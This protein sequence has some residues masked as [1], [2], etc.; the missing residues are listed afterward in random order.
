MMHPQF[1]SRHSVK[2]RTIFWLAKPGSGSRCWLFLELLLVLVTPA[3]T[4]LLTVNVVYI[5]SLPMKSFNRKYFFLQRL[6]Q[7]K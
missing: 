5:S 6:E 7:L 2:A 1:S 4:I 3:I